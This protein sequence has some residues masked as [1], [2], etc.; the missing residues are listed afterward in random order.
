M[1]QKY[2]P[3]S[4]EG[5]KVVSASEM[6]R[7]E[8]V[9][10]LEG[11]ATAD[12]YMEKAALG[13]LDIVLRYI[14]EKKLPRTVLLLCGKGNNGGDCFSVGEKLLAIGYKVAAHHLFPISDCSQLCQIHANGFLKMGGEIY[15]VGEIVIPPN[16]L[17]LDG[18]LGTG[19]HGKVTG[20]M[21]EVID[22][23]NAAQNPVIS[24]DIPSGVAGD[25]GRVETVA[26]I[27]E[28]TAYLGLMK[29]GHLY[30]QGFDYVGNLI[31]VDFGLSKQYVEKA[32]PFGYIVNQEIVSKN[33]P[34]R[35]RTANK[36]SVG[37]VVLVAGSPGMPG[38]AIIAAMG[39]QKMGA[40]IIRLF[41]SPGMECE[42]A[43][44][45][46]EVVRMSQIQTLLEELH[47]TKAIL[48]GPGL[49]RTGDIPKLLDLLYSK[50]KCPI[51]IDGDALFFFKGGVENAILTPHKGE[52]QKLLQLDESLGDLDLIKKAEEFSLLHNIIIVYKGPATTIISPNHPKIII[53][54]GTS[55]MSTAGMGDALAGI[56]T[57]LIAQ[58]AS[59][60]LAATLGATL[61]A[62]AGAKSPSPLTA[63][64]LI[65]YL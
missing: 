65:T 57:T 11:D 54:F 16:I 56:I 60:H 53:P 49:G 26:V 10:I 2:F 9:A 15:P 47:R 52:L 43:A 42:L 21:K 22:K 23:V 20:L 17:I 61:H 39:A 35:V 24:I 55:N 25:T 6:A 5:D 30:N 8:S 44:L 14:E 3:V 34:I 50:A 51:V 58:G 27:A 64:K 48:V 45:P 33:L 19:F 38:A 28:I 36:Y 59:L 62:L 7:I 1:T 63:S 18:L 40:G 46:P 37:Q 32:L 31:K 41:H 12:Q 29:V 13:I 4:V